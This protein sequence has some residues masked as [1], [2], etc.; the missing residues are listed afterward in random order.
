MQKKGTR[1]KDCG[2][3]ILDWAAIV[4]SQN[5]KEKKKTSFFK[6]PV[7]QFYTP[8]AR[9][10]HG[11]EEVVTH[12]KYFKLLKK[13]LRNQTAFWYMPVQ[14]FSSLFFWHNMQVVN[15]HSHMDNLRKKEVSLVRRVLP[16]FK[17]TFELKIP[18]TCMGRYCVMGVDMAIINVHFSHEL[19]EWC[20]PPTA[21][22]LVPRNV[23]YSWCPHLGS[24]DCN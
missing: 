1:E 19:I 9:I 15:Q 16:E 23:N 21:F 6:V 12:K 5:K 18:T 7:K 14:N 8:Q 10:L 4:V 22:N 13:L 11:H 20:Q 3:D 2:S 17:S 24:H